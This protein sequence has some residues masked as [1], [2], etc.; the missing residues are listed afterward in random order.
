MK[1][2]NAM[3]Q[4][5]RIN[6]FLA[7]CGVASRRASESLIIS[8][9]VTVNGDVMTSLACQIDPE[10]DTVTVHGK[11]IALPQENSVVLMLN[12]PAGYLTT[13]SDP[14]GRKTV[15]DLL[16]L[17]RYPGLF[18]IGRLDQDTRGLLLFT[19]DGEL[20]NAL[21][22][23]SFHVD[24]TYHARV[25]GR[26]SE[27]SLY[28]LE[29]GLVLDDGPTAPARARVCSYDPHTQT[30]WVELTIHEGRKRQVKRMM[31]AIGHP[32]KELV[33]KSLGPL[34]LSNLELGEWRE[35]TDDEIQ[36]LKA[37]VLTD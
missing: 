17:E 37:S 1:T 19:T 20:G 18:P 26:V 30:S 31:Q 29:N 28:K 3:T 16:P 9:A 35:L 4:M 32:V 2:I 6:K 25:A 33:R 27:R 7:R 36:K 5:M 24:K 11:P 13:M 34:T 12:K 23:P 15:A 8:G 22:H 10:H 21:L 14:H